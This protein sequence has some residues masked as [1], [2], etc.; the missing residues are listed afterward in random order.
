MVR[1][2][3]IVQGEGRGHLSQSVALKE[4]LEKDGHTVEAVFAGSSHS[5]PLPA[6]FQD[7]FKDKLIPFSSPR[8]LRT[9]NKKG[10]YVASTILFN[11]VRGITYLREVLRIRREIKLHKPD[12]VIN[13]Y[14]VIGALAMR[15]LSPAIRR[16]GIG[17][18][19]FLHLD[20]YRCYGGKAFHKMLLKLHTRIVLASCDRVL[21]L[22]FRKVPGTDRITVVPP[23][24]RRQFREARYERGSAYLVYLLNEGFVVD[25]IHLVRD[26]PEL[27][28]DIFSDLPHQTPVPDGITLHRVNDLEFSEKMKQCRG[29]ITTA[30]FDTAAEAA[31]MGIPLAVIPVENHFEQLCNSGDVERSG[32][33]IVLKDFSAASLAEM[34]EIDQKS[35]RRWVDNAGIEILK[36][37]T[38]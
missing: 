6:Y 17:H 33:G 32:V 15:K 14:D 22:S 2:L 25:L 34:M 28:F 8:F 23:L 9:P 16:I 18:H 7:V 13:F 11:L 24:V 30:G 26:H 19:F 31:C 37:L 4:Y 38:G 27:V 36:Q 10:I 20:G 5:N 21:A 29:V 1:T 35:Y 12:V 3:F